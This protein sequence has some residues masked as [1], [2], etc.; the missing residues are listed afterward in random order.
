MFKHADGPK[1][2]QIRK[3]RSPLILTTLFR[4]A[5]SF[6]DEQKVYGT[7]CRRK[8]SPESLHCL[9]VFKYIG[10]TLSASHLDRV[11]FCSL[12]FSQRI[13]GFGGSICDLVHVCL[14]NE[15]D[16]STCALTSTPGWAGDQKSFNWNIK[17]LNSLQ[18]FQNPFNTP[19]KLSPSA[20]RGI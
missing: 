8:V 5:A 14:F 18:K 11:P 17:M 4:R 7:F 6:S 10:T 2:R 12:R 3:L 9:L 16:F 13:A 1:E 15:N 19:Q 20:L